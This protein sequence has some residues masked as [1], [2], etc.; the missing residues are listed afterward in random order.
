MSRRRQPPP[1]PDPRPSSP[2][3]IT[4]PIREHIP[5]QD[6]SS[7]TS[8]ENVLGASA[9]GATYL[10][11]LQLFT[12]LLTFTFNHLILRHT[13]PSIFGLA[14]IQ[15]DLLASTILFLSREGFRVSL[16]RHPGHLQRTV[17]L[18]YIPLATGIL[19][20]CLGCFLF[21]STAR[22]EVAQIGGFK[23]SVLL[24]GFSAIIELVGEAGFNVAQE[25]LLF[26]TRSLAEGMGVVSKC[27][28]TYF[29]MIWFLKRGRLEEV[30]A[31][32]FALG[33]LAYSSVV[34]G[35]YL[36]V[37]SRKVNLLPRK[38][39][40]QQTEA[41]KREEGKD[42]T[43]GNR[44]Y[45]FHGPSLRLAFSVTG[46]SLFKHLLT[47]GDKLVLTFLTTPYTQGIYSVVSNYGTFL[48]SF[49]LPHLPP[50]CFAE[51][52]DLTE[53]SIQELTRFVNK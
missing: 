23:E 51:I 13:S 8:S 36:F 2:P 18:S 53:R 22:E 30:G 40:P 17:N 35:V 12:R 46:Q 15:L 6:A 11:L 4:Q 27:L 34:T 28:G 33:Q 31:I 29:W 39:T 5:A 38:V 24:F 32:P 26:R 14:T 3:S 47:E 50:L 52:P 7:D 37:I 21:L 9:R 48:P 49:H 20:T 19:G 45:W 10:I 41:T 1:P 42:G 16:Q 44:G 25:M 43:R